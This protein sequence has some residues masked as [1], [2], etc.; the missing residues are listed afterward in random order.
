MASCQEGQADA[1]PGSPRAAN[2]AAAPINQAKPCIMF[3]C[4]ADIL[5]QPHTEG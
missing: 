4:I 5:A 2:S 1:D 3:L